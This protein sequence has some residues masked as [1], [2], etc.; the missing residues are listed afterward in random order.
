[1]HTGKHY[2]LKEVGLWTRHETAI[3]F[4]IA[5]VPT[6]LYVIAGWKWLALPWL[7]IATVGT[8]V[9]FITGFKNNTSYSRLWEARQVWGSIINGSRIWGV[10]TLDFITMPANSAE[11]E[12]IRSIQQRLF[13]RHLAWI[14]TVRYQLREKRPWENMQA[15]YNVEY[16]RNYH[17]PE[18]E[19]NLE[20]E[21]K[22]LLDPLELAYILSKKNRAT[23]L[24]TLQSRE[25]RELV[26]KGYL[27][28]YRQCQM[29][30]R[31]AEFYND[32][33][34]CER[35]KNFPY[36]RQFA[37][38]NLFFVW[39]FIILVPFG[40]LQE[41]QKIGGGYVWLTIPSSIIAA[42]VFHTMDKIGESS[43]N[44]FEGG[45]NDVPIT[46][47][48]RTIEIDLREMLNETDIPAP[49]QATNNILM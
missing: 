42:W 21:L 10:L 13:Y 49:T 9:A 41:F 44:P 7:P 12:Q 15:Q 29:E 33:G 19:G 14:T 37:T 38:L 31:I 45:P 6:V 28:E 36:P 5:T 2:S 34:R 16:R 47:M 40:M 3:F 48:S 26:E 25:L 43:E 39:L 1:M 30:E 20:E 22:A 8:A 4:V 27:T 32:Q 23:H 17:V 35:I 46:S 24:L 18:W 11:A